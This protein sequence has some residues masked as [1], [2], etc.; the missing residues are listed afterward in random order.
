[1]K[2]YI[3]NLVRKTNKDLVLFVSLFLLFNR[4]THY[5]VGVV[6]RQFFGDN[7]NW[8]VERW[9]LDSD[10]SVRLRLNSSLNHGLFS[11]LFSLGENG[12][13][14]SQV[15]FGGWLL[16]M[17]VYLLHKIGLLSAADYSLP[18]PE[19]GLSGSIGLLLLYSF[20][21]CINA[22]LIFVTAKW[23]SRSFSTA[24]M[25]LFLL[26][27]LSPWSLS[28]QSSLFWIIGLK[29]LPGFVV[30]YL[31]FRRT[32][33]LRKISLTLFATTVLAYLSGYEFATL[34]FVGPISALL[35]ISLVES[36]K[37]KK[38][39]IYFATVIS[40]SLV[41]FIFTLGLHFLQLIFSLGSVNL[42]KL[43]FTQVISKR[44]GITRENFGDLYS[45]SLSSDPIEVLNTYFSMPIFGAPYR[46]AI[47]S[48][49]TVLSFVLLVFLFWIL[50][51]LLIDS[52]D[53]VSRY[54]ALG[55]AWLV[56]LLSP[57]GWYLLARPHSFGHT[58][59]DF[60]LWFLPSIPIGA[61]FVAVPISLLIDR[62]KRD[63][64]IRRVTLFFVLAV[65]LMMVESYL[66]IVK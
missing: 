11:H 33:T 31:Y 38:N 34:I 15:G 62:F 50:I 30:G 58:H 59:I 26:T 18:A 65:T 25:V 36:W 44:T 42:A 57:I 16:T 24:S 61:I 40:T 45:L 64:F 23:V 2:E 13:Y 12:S 1:M 56:S 9:Q 37:K 49:F 7:F 28:V 35:Y 63:P 47:L 5:V 43:E 27:F 20:V 39:I 53:L 46:I 14:L 17:P 10:M 8:F 4:Y 32:F 66:T 48:N 52:K 60:V 41:A 19:M 22:S 3:S 54:N 55:A 6:T 21:A 51:P 29:I